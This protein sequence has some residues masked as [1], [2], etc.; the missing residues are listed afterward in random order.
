MNR[1]GRRGV[2]GS[3]TLKERCVENIGL[4]LTTTAAVLVV[5]MPS[6][7]VRLIGTV[8][9]VG[10]LIYMYKNKPKIRGK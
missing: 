3:L 2:E 8:T 7:E 6:V 1:G 4:V 10:G 9:E 5:G